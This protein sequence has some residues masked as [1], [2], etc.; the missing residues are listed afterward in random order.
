MIDWA[1]KIVW[2]YQN[3]IVPP[4]KKEV[5]PINSTSTEFDVL[6]NKFKDAK[7][8]SWWA[9]FFE[10]LKKVNEP[11]ETR[12]LWPAVVVDISTEDIKEW[13]KNATHEILYY[14]SDPVKNKVEIYA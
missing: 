2:V 10:L 13:T 11:K 7:K 5:D 4:V 3:N 1:N 12:E 6:L 9:Y 14:N 8:G